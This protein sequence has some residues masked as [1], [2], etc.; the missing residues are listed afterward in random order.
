MPSR[1]YPGSFGS[2]NVSFILNQMLQTMLFYSYG[3]AFFIVKNAFREQ[4]KQLTIGVFCKAIL[5]FQDVPPL[6]YSQSL[7]QSGLCAI[8]A[9]YFMSFPFTFLNRNVGYN[10]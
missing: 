6:L 5:H 4:K 3:K 8:S 9:H 1:K 2:K 10:S 7:D